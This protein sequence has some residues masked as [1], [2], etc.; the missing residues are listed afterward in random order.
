MSAFSSFV[1]LPPLRKKNVQRQILL[2]G[3]RAVCVQMCMLQWGVSCENRR[4][5]AACDTLNRQHIRFDGHK[6]SFLSA[7]VDASECCGEHSCQMN[8]RA[9][10]AWYACFPLEANLHTRGMVEANDL[11]QRVFNS[12]GRA[13]MTDYRPRVHVRFAQGVYCFFVRDAHAPPH[14]LAQSYVQ[15]QVDAVCV[16]TLFAPSTE[17][18]LIVFTFRLSPRR[19][20]WYDTL[21]DKGSGY[22]QHVAAWTEQFLRD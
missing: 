13:F 1:A 17:P 5:E 9:Y 20:A 4:S 18:F 21:P 10:Q 3:R 16:G 14:V 15:D 2:T 8:C 19:V 12:T 22:G 7:H 6:L 11:M